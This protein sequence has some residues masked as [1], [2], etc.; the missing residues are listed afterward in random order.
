MCQ[1][2]LNRAS[3]QASVGS[4]RLMGEANGPVRILGCVTIEVKVNDKRGKASIV[5]YEVRQ[6]TVHQVGIE[7]DMCHHGYSS[8]W[9]SCW[10][11]DLRKMP[12]RDF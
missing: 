10:Q 2:G 8:C 3:R 9:Y 6:K 7:V 11:R 4:D 5:P 1:R 12:P